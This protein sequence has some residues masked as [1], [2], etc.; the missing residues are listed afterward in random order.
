[1][2]V[3][4]GLHAK[5]Q[6]FLTRHP[7]I[8]LLSADSQAER[9]RFIKSGVVPFVRHDGYRFFMMKP[10]PRRPGLG[11]PMF[12]ICKG[13]RMHYI[14]GRGWEDLRDDTA[15]PGRK[16]TLP[17]TAI[18][19]GIEELG[20][21][22]ESFRQMFDVG[23]YTF[24]SAKTGMTRGMWLFAL[25]LHSM[26]DV[27][28]MSDVAPTTAERCWLGLE[29]F[30]VVGRDDHRYILGDIAAKLRAYHTS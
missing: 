4:D 7:I 1:M 15:S 23:P 11:A 22:L 19:E 21:K 13:T 28:P 17:A 6:D 9:D 24:A 2:Q 14:E 18:R 3:H 16:E 30:M 8:P 27:L 12:Q 25:E 5:I 26:D 10:V 20:L 29:Q